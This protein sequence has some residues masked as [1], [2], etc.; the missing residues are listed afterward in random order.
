[1]NVDRYITEVHKDAEKA[2]SLAQRSGLA[3]DYEKAAELYDKSG[4]DYMAMV[5]R[6][7]AERLAG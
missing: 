1:M 6:N 4:D 7:A 3:A 5:C 2:H